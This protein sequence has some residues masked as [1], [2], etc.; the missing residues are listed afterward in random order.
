MRV[1]KKHADQ[2]FEIPLIPMIDCMFVLLVFFLVAT[3]LKRTE[4]ELPIDLPQSGAALNMEQ[5]E[6]TLVIGVDRNGQKFFG[7]EPVSTEILHQRLSAAALANPNRRVR[8]DADVSTPY[9]A[10][11]ELVEMCQFN[12]LRNVGFHTRK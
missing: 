1:S 7:S 5:K 10:V 12:N 3:T 6:D 8:I 11:V 2:D 9:V 4:R